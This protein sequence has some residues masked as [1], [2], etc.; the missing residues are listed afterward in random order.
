MTNMIDSIPEGYSTVTPYLI[1]K[2]VAKSMDFYRKAFNAA[3][4]MHIRDSAGRTMHAEIQIGSSLIILAD[5]QPEMQIL[6]PESLGGT[7][8]ALHL[9]VQNADALFHQA[10]QAGAQVV[11]PMKDQLSGDRCGS[12][13]DPFGHLWHLAARQEKVDFD[14]QQLRVENLLCATTDGGWK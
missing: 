10:L 11:S 5:E 1:I 3:G 7:P 12:V 6:S 2:D 4:L 14:E 9:Y 13:R 8:V